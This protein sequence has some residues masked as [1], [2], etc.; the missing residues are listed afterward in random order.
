MENITS[1]LSKDLM[2]I[3]LQ[4]V[5]IDKPS[6]YIKIMALYDHR[7]GLLEINDLYSY[8][9]SILNDL[10]T[11]HTLIG[12][13]GEAKMP[14]LFLK[15]NLGHFLMSMLYTEVRKTYSISE[16]LSLANEL[17]IKKRNKEYTRAWIYKCVDNDQL[18]ATKKP[19]GS[20][21]CYHDDVQV[22]L[23]SKKLL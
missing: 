13:P 8:V 3:E 23:K 6:T 15:S 1:I 10:F 16:V 19:D 2:E 7:D 12:E 9:Y 11:P 5:K 17:S 22:F 21:F 18:R 14:I 4:Q 20:M